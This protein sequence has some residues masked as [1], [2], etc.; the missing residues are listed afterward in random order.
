MPKDVRDGREHIMLIL[1]RREVAE[2]A[3]GGK[4][5]M[6]ILMVVFPGGGQPDSKP[7]WHETG[8]EGVFTPFKVETKVWLEG[9][10]LRLPS[11]LTPKL[12]PKRYGPF[13]V[14]TQI[15]KVAYKL[16]LPPT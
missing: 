7:D 13:E 3:E 2:P 16:K 6:E 15:S 10:N 8:Q 4:G 14:A 11:N 9:T 5:L 12:A 1:D